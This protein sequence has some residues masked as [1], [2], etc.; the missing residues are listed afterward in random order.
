MYTRN[1]IGRRRAPG[2]AE[3]RRHF[4]RLIEFARPKTLKDEEAQK[5]ER[6]IEKD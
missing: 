3:R 5:P 1:T 4:R 6:A 2:W